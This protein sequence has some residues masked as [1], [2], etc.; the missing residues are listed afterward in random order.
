MRVCHT[1]EYY[2]IIKTGTVDNY[3]K[4]LIYA[5]KKVEV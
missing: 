1:N 2:A 4:M 5:M 3:G